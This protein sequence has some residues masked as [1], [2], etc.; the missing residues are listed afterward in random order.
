[1]RV[2]EATRGGEDI[3]HGEAGNC[4]RR[5]SRIT[6]GDSSIAVPFRRSSPIPS[7]RRAPTG[8]ASITT[9]SF[10]PFPQAPHYFS[11]S[12]VFPVIS[13]GPVPLSVVTFPC[14]VTTTSYV[15][16]GNGGPVGRLVSDGPVQFRPSQS[17]GWR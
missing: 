16:A 6:G 4:P 13:Y 5:T 14:T 10:H 11:T 7:R 9:F 1:M 17:K 3:P 2:T 12:F 8:G 15:P